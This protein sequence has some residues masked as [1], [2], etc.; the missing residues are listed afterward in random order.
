VE[1]EESGHKV[2]PFTIEMKKKEKK[3]D[4]SSKKSYRNK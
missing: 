3:F 1:E 4:S 2:D